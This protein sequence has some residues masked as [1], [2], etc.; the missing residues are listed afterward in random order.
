MFY[1]INLNA[2]Q[3]RQANDSASIVKRSKKDFAIAR[4]KESAARDQMRT[5]RLSK[6]F[7]SVNNSFC[8]Y[9]TG[10][11]DKGN[12]CLSRGTLVNKLH[13]SKEHMKTL[14]SL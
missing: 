13:S 8:L 3:S 2:R 9:N 7:E 5:R 6:E 4:C 11:Q 14:G 10:R 12:F 1:V